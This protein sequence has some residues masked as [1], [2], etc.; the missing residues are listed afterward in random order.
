MLM[1]MRILHIGLGVFWAGTLFFTAFFLFPAMRD[2]G[3]DGAKVGAQLMKRNFT[4]IMPVTAIVTILAGLW[5]YWRVSGGFQPDYMRT[6]T[7]MSYGTGGATAILALIIGL[8]VVRPAML[9]ATEL[10]GTPEA[11]ALRA[12]AGKANLWVALLLVITLITMAVGRYV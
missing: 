3:P 11:Q 5:L 9:K 1:L 6:T 12:R 4:T 2:A 10:G 8:A 7:A